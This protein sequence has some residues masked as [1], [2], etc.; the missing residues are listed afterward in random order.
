[1]ADLEKTFIVMTGADTAFDVLSDPMRLADYVPALDL[2]DST[3]VDGELDPDAD[4][5]ERDGAPA[6]EYMADR[7]TR[8]IE[9]GRPSPDY[10]GSITIATGTTN[11]SRVTVRLHTAPDA[12]REGVTRMFD[13][14]VADIRRILSGR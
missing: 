5:K 11:T 14:S 6:G 13:E 12:D 3:A 7:A 1:M 2:V 9:W 4:L 8:S 10:G